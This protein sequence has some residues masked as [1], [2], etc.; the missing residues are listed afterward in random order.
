MGWRN[1]VRFRRRI[2]PIAGDI[3]SNRFSPEE[4][5][6]SSSKKVVANLRPNIVLRKSS[7]APTDSA[8]GGRAKFGRPSPFGA[9]KPSRWYRFGEGPAGRI[10]PPQALRGAK[11]LARLQ[12]RR[13]AGGPNL[14]APSP[15]G[16]GSP[17]AATDLANGRRAEFGR[18]SPLR[19]KGPR[20]R[21][22]TATGGRAKFG[23]PSPF[24]PRKSSRA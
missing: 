10:W 18:P 6:F 9:R 5:N 24:G 8:N 16:R 7:P 13:T 3:S 12:I 17:R 22:Q 21:T 14:A 4:I 20:A 2:R 15:L 23:R 11:A 1:K 19:R